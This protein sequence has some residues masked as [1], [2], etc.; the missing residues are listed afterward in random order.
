[1][2]LILIC[3]LLMSLQRDFPEDDDAHAATKMKNSWRALRALRPFAV[4]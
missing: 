2:I 4:K 3:T 1:M